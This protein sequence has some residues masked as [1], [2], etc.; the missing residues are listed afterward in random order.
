M[1]TALSPGIRA[2]TP[3]AVRIGS[4]VIEGVP[5]SS[6]DS[7]TTAEPS[8]KRCR[9]QSE[10]SNA[11]SSNTGSLTLLRESCLQVRTSAILRLHSVTFALANAFSIAVA[12]RFLPK[13]LSSAEKFRRVSTPSA[14][15]ESAFVPPI[16]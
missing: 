8:L 15:N 9:G 13:V 1:S 3:K 11:S 2:E 10:A 6:P 4:L 12:S 16:N 7:D 5:L 14:V